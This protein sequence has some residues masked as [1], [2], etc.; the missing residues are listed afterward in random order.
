MKTSEIYSD[1]LRKSSGSGQ[2]RTPGDEIITGLD[3]LGAVYREWEYLVN[4]ENSSVNSQDEVYYEAVERLAELDYS[5]ED[6]QEFALELND[7]IGEYDY[8]ERIGAGLYISAGIEC[9]DHQKVKLPGLDRVDNLGHRNSGELLVDGDVGNCLGDKM[10]GGRIEVR[11]STGGSPGR[12]M[13]GGEIEV[14]GSSAGNVG[15][16]MKN[17]KIKV[18]QEAGETIGHEME[19]GVIEVGSCGDFVGQKMKGGEIKVQGNA[20]SE[21]GFGMEN[22]EIHIQGDAG[23]V[24]SD[25]IGGR[26]VIEGDAEHVGDGPSGQGPMVGGEIYVAGDFELSDRIEG[27]EIYQRVNNEWQL[28]EDFQ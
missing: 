1:I 25:L 24:G 27:G 22:G 17:G 7:S 14:L 3:S 12:H 20:E 4:S 9:L 15:R 10:V 19:D 2:E 23:S 13:K 8:T 28:V 18:H 26:I 5:E 21:V 11:G 16:K 6:L